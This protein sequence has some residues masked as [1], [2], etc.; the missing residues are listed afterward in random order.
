MDEEN[1]SIDEEEIKNE[2]KDT[3]NQVKD[4]I[5]N[6]DFKTNVN[7]TK[8]LIKDLI[9]SPIEAVKRA[10]NGEENLLPKAIILMIAFIVAYLG[11]NMSTIATTV[12]FSTKIFRI[13]ISIIYPVLYVAVPAFM[14]LLLNKKNK[15]PLIRNICTMVVV[16]VPEIVGYLVII[17]GT[18]INGITVLTQPV[19]TALSAL[20]I[21]LMYFGI[22]ELL[23]EEDEKKA[24]T[25][26]IVIKLVTAFV[27]LLLLRIK[28]F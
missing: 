8:G 22:K 26:F 18:L 21:I 4:S 5:K 14:V 16:S 1:F 9:L 13:I 17:L 6:S 11:Y 10:A 15:K 3:V 25:K 20:T 7:E 27:L 12:K 28:P 23:G 24:V 2:T 19:A